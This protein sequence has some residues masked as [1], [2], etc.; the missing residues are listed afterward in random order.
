MRRSYWESFGLPVIYLYLGRREAWDQYATG[1]SYFSQAST[2]DQGQGK[3]DD[4][5]RGLS[6]AK[7]RQAGAEA[8]MERKVKR[9]Q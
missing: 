7:N 1:S 8:L 5:D 3:G 6:W 2:R 9:T 4:M